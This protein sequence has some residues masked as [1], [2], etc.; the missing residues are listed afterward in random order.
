MTGKFLQKPSLYASPMSSVIDE[1][2]LYQED[3]QAVQEWWK[4]SRWRYTKRPYIA[5]QI[6]AKRGN[7]EVDFPSNVLSKKLWRILEDRFEV[8]LHRIIVN[9]FANYLKA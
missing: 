1:D 9:P 6:A 2:R 5:E 3:V 7:I 4:D 8:C